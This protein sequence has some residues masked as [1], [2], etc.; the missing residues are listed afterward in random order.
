MSRLLRSPLFRQSFLRNGGLRWSH[1]LINASTPRA[2][3]AL[4]ELNR[5]KALNALSTPLITELNSHIKDLDS[6]AEIGAIVLT[7]G[8]KVFAGRP[9]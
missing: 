2:R 3:V 5:P 7:G 8:E 6:N 9:A 4:I 1:T